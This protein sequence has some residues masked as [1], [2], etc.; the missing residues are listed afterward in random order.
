MAASA[1]T[2][3]GADS[4]R[5]LQRAASKARGYEGYVGPKARRL[6]RR[7]AGQAHQ[8]GSEEQLAALDVGHLPQF[9]DTGTCPRGEYP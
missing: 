6:P 5:P 3:E 2:N 1:W 4:S 8:K 9:N 7:G